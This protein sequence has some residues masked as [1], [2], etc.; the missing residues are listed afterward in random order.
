[1]STETDVK[2]TLTGK[3]VSN[4]SDKTIVV[5]TTRK[6]RDRIYKKYVTRTKKFHAHDEANACNIGDIVRIKETRPLS[7]LKTWVLEEIIEKVK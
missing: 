5:Q 6:V 3:V 7:K 1:M 4:K 2:R